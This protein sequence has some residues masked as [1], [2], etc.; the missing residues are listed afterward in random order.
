MRILLILMSFALVIGCNKSQS[1]SSAN[2]ESSV[3]TE[4]KTQDATPRLNV[5]G[6]LLEKG[7]CALLVTFPE[8]PEGSEWLSM[9]TL[10]G[11]H[12]TD[13]LPRIPLASSH[14]VT[15]LNIPPGRYEVDAKA[16]VRKNAP[17][18]GG[19]SDS[20]TFVPGELLI[21]KAQLASA[22]DGSIEG[23]QLR[24]GGRTTWSLSSPR[25]L[26]KYIADAASS[27][28]G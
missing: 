2:T 12:D 28:K 10:K 16:W 21:L 4:S 24:E 9:V 23:F 11:D 5:G 17:Y 14:T 15:V 26:S 7:Y 22:A 8:A 1:D 19:I 20:V 27:A 18:A 25:D 13:K 6:V 3:K